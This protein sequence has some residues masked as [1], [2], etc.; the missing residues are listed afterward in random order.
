M[1]HGADPPHPANTCGEQQTQPLLHK[2]RCPAE[3]SRDQPNSSQPKD[4]QVTI[5][6]CSFTLLSFEVTVL[7]K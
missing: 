7:H 1:K 4:T 5:S 6:N 2:A 3:S